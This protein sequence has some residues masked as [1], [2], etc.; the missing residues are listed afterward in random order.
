MN[1]ERQAT[2]KD[3]CKHRNRL[4]EHMN[5]RELTNIIVHEKFKILFCYI[6]RLACTQW[7]TTMVHLSRRKPKYWIHDGSN[8]KFL[9][10][11]PRVEVEKMLK[12]YLKFVT[13]VRT[14]R[15]TLIAY[16]NNFTI[17][18]QLST[19]YG[20]AILYSETRRNEYNI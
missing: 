19:S 6:P 13:C 3:F 16:V 5:T 20:D 12:T 7:K 8:F 10:H 11:Y 18:T 17:T 14:F 15:A 9:A 1:L 4:N 2:I